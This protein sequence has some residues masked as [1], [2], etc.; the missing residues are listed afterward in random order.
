MSLLKRFLTKFA[1]LHLLPLLK[2]NLKLIIIF[3]LN[4]YTHTYMYV[5]M[6]LQFMYVKIRP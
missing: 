2:Y 6:N 3:L 4:S 1:I 5:Y